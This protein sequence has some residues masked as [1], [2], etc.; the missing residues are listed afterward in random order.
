[1][2]VLSDNRL[3]LAADYERT[4]A[5][6]GFPTSLQLCHQASR[7]VADPFTEECRTSLLGLSAMGASWHGPC[8]SPSARLLPYWIALGS[9]WQARPARSQETRCYQ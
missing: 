5:T 2:S 9:H 8:A 3:S 7:T 1:M 4:L 6:D